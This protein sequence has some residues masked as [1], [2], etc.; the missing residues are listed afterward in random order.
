MPKSET[1]TKS[2]I[3][4]ETDHTRKRFQVPRTSRTPRNRSVRIFTCGTLF[5]SVRPY[6]TQRTR[7]GLRARR[8]RRRL[9]RRLADPS[10]V[11]LVVCLGRDPGEEGAL[12]G[13]REFADHNHSPELGRVAGLNFEPERAERSG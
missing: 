5:S 8:R 7:R 4:P 3:S 2:A 1:P 11:A 10:Q 9:R 6:E 13:G 12:I